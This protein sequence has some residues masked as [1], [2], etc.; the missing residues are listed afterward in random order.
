MFSAEGLDVIM[1]KIRATRTILL[2]LVAVEGCSVDSQLRR[3]FFLWHCALGVT[4][5]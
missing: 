3:L 4:P 1:K 5:S 2:V